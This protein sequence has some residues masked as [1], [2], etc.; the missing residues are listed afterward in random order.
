[1]HTCPPKD[2][3]IGATTGFFGPL[4]FMLMAPGFFTPPMFIEIP[5]GFLPRGDSTGADFITFG[6]DV[7]YDW[8]SAFLFCGLTLLASWTSPADQKLRKLK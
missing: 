5:V 3:L 7:L 6:A 1:M 4:I 2:I 8:F